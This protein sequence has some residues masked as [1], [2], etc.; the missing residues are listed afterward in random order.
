MRKMLQLLKTRISSL[1]K[2]FAR[3]KGTRILAICFEISDGTE[4]S[5][6]I[7]ISEK[8]LFVKDGQREI[9]VGGK[10]LRFS[11]SERSPGVGTIELENPEDGY[12]IQQ[13]FTEN[14]KNW[15]FEGAYRKPV[16]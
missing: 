14:K 13:L 10:P 7:Y 4:T 8:R 15:K 6:L 5:Y 9:T 16:Y 12:K 3:E 2:F 11:L 1:L